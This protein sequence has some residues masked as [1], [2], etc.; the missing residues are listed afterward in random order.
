MKAIMME[1]MELQKKCHEAAAEFMGH[2]Y[3]PPTVL[4]LQVRMQIQHACACGYS[5]GYRDRELEEENDPD[6]K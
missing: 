2:M 3:P 5:K 4:D 6:C 1:D